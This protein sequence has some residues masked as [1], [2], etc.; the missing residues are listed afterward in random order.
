MGADS[1]GRNKTISLSIRALASGF[2]TAFDSMSG[3]KVK[4]G[5]QLHPPTNLNLKGRG[6]RGKDKV[7][8]R[9]G[10][11]VKCPSTGPATRREF[12]AQPLNFHSTS[13]DSLKIVNRLKEG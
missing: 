2:F 11:N 9:M 12:S 5:E 3:G 1:V 8:R 6:W 13:S 4:R 10:E 7:L